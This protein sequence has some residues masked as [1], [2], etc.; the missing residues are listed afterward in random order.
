MVGNRKNGTFKIS[1][2]GK[3]KANGRRIDG[4]W[5]ASG[6]EADRYLQLKAMLETGKISKLELQPIYNIVIGGQH[7]CSY[8]GDFRYLVPDPAI[9][10]V[11]VLE[12]VKGFP[13][14]EYLLKKKL[15]LAVHKEK[16]FELPGKW[17]KHFAGL[18]AL[19][20]DLP[21]DTLQAALEEK[22]RV[23]KLK[24]KERRKARAAAAAPPPSLGEGAASPPGDTPEPET[25][26]EDA[27]A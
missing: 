9:G 15:M 18:T 27:H 17:M 22:R 26:Q 8:R 13:T 23:R 12:D 6:Y 20:C 10:F 14:K 25:Q 24:D 3:Y 4:H 7:I 21:I 16:I 11:R 19:E 5:F 1:Q 2:V